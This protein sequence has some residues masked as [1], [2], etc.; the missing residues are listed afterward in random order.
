VS[1]KSRPGSRYVGLPHYLLNSLAWRTLPGDAVKVLIDVWKRHNGV[2]NGE[3]SYGVREAAEIGITKTP[4]ARMLH[5]LVERGFLAIVRDSAFNVKTKQVRTWRLTA[6]PYRGQQGTNDFM[7]WRPSQNLKH[8][9]ST[10]T[11]SPSTGTRV[12]KLPVTVPPQGLSDPKTPPPQSL[13]RDTYR[14]PR[15]ERPPPTLGLDP[16]G[17]DRPMASWEGED[18]DGK[19]GSDRAVGPDG[20]RCPEHAAE[21]HPLNNSL[22]TAAKKIARGPENRVRPNF[23]RN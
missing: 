16:A 11:H 12:T 7:R 18:E 14:L 13:H 19:P 21:P 10:G 9:P 17:S 1:K 23:G 22:I 15:M 4:A 6:E 3:I 20:E 5:I 2:N 8:S